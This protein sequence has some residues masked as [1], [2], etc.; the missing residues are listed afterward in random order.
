M[1]VVELLRKNGPSNEKIASELG[2]NTG[3]VRNLIE[4]ACDRTG[5]SNRVELA[6]WA[7]RTMP[8]ADIERL[9]LPKDIVAGMDQTDR[10][11]I[12]MIQKCGATSGEIAN[13]LGLDEDAVHHR[14][15]KIYSKL[16]IKGRMELALSEP[17]DTTQQAAHTVSELPTSLQPHPSF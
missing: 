3:T 12:K 5:A 4:K 2:I 16:H 17:I 13:E 14:L 6:V 1:R 15:S 8:D 9:E 11:I 10:E 7:R